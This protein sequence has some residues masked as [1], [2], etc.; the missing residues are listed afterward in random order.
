MKRLGFALSMTL[1]CTGLLAQ[2]APSPCRPLFTT[3]AALTDIGAVDLQFGA[4]RGSH[5]NGAQITAFPT[6]I[7]LGLTSWFDFRAAWSGHNR[8]RDNE[9]N[10]SDGFGDPQIGG[11]VFFAPQDKLGVDLGLAYWHKIPRASVVKGIGSGKVDD[12][13][14]LVLS[15]T[16]G[17]WEWDLNVGANWLGRSEGSRVRQAV[18]SICVTYLAAPGWNITLD[19]YAVGKTELGPNTVSSIL[20]VS[21]RVSPSLVLD[22]AV[23]AGL[24][25]AATKLT[26]NAGLV[27]R[28]GRIWNPSN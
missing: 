22:V 21:R 24:N 23:E 16:D 5:W 7:D 4:Q 15:R 17:C 27:W 8:L 14:V 20:A 13:G 10:C 2:E 28:V 25:Q 6:E 18:G 12:S 19:T 26:L 11:Q 3:S 9:G 1:V